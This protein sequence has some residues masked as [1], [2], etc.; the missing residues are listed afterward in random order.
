MEQQKL[1]AKTKLKG[2]WT[3]H[4]EGENVELNIS[5]VY[6]SKLLSNLFLKKKLIQDFFFSWLVRHMGHKDISWSPRLVMLVG[7]TYGGNKGSSLF[8]RLANL[9]GNYS[10]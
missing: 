3:A 10:S 2:D 6:D 9:L 5:V 7:K 4:K 8:A 1:G